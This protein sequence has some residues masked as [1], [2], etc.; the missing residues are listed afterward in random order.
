MQPSPL[1]SLPCP[2]SATLPLLLGL[3][4]FPAP[5]R[6]SDRTPLPRLP[7]RKRYKTPYITLPEANLNDA[8]GS[9]GRSG[10]QSFIPKSQD[11]AP[12]RRRRCASD[13]NRCSLAEA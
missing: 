4:Q 11:A 7:H 2:P 1:H 9:K 12:T 5:L 13:S 10:L 8:E 6:I 3:P